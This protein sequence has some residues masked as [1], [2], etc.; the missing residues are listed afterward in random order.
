MATLFDPIGSEEEQLIVQKEFQLIRRNFFPNWDPLGKWSIEAFYFDDG[1]LGFCPL[2]YKDIFI[3]TD[4]LLR[5]DGKLLLETDLRTTIIHETAHAVAPRWCNHGQR[6]QD[7]IKKC[8]KMAEQLGMRDLS[9]MLFRELILFYGA[10]GVRNNHN[11]LFTKIRKLFRQR[12][13]PTFEEM[14]LDIVGLA[15]KAP[16]GNIN[17]LER[18]WP[19]RKFYNL[20]KLRISRK[21]R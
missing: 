16:I 12:P 18:L 20:E 8:M 21:K 3:N 1:R 17:V 4:L 5:C 15:G 19:L 13:I 10:R 14:M 9:L 7:I 2:H 11:A 6:W